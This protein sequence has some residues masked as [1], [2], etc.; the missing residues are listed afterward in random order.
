M[1]ATP[2]RARIWKGR[3]YFVVGAVVVVAVCLTLHHFSGPRPASAQAPQQQATAQPTNRVPSAKPAGSST[4]PLTVVASVNG[5]QITRQELA[6]ECLRRYGTDVI[7]SI[8]NKHL[9]WQAC[10]SHGLEITEKDVDDEI[11]RLATKFGLSPGR[12]LTLLQQERD[13]SPEQYR[14]EIIWPTLALKALAA[15]ELVV[16]PEEM[17]MAMEAEYGPRVKARA[18]LPS[19]LRH[20]PTNCVPRPWRLPT[21]SGR[22]PRNTRRT[23]VPAC[24]A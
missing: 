14:R 9:I 23:R 4:K 17:Q 15:K 19:V 24:T 22:W 7:E 18:S 8:V 2:R 10:Q 16:T 5:E 20:L 21:S 12:W 6:D 13:L 3:I 11:A 1:P